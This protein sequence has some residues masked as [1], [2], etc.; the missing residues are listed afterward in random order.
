MNVEEKIKKLLRLAGQK[1]SAEEAA[2]AYGQ[3]Q[4]LATLYRL[5]LADLEDAEVSELEPRQVEEIE[6]RL[7]VEWDRVVLWKM[8]LIAALA[9]ANACGSFYR[10]GHG[11]G[12]YAYGQP[13]DLDAIAYMYS[14]IARDVDRIATAAV[15]AWRG[16]ESPRSYGR[17]FRL[18]MVATLKKRLASQRSVVAEA[19]E[20]V[21]RARLAAIDDLEAM[22]TATTALARVC[23]I[24]V[25][26]EQVEVAIGEY[27]KGLGLKGGQSFAGVGAGYYDGRRAGE[28]VSLARGARALKG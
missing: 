27:R 8:R 3:A 17:S 26:Q 6:Q 14:A 28:R 18:G 23:A 20:D 2:T 5:N 19:K 25:Y 16:R 24:E 10:S 9:D 11:T 21:E 7:I 22:A 1:D 13:S 15:A 4:R 12:C